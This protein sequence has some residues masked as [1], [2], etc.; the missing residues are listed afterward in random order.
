MADE[1]AIRI[2][3]ITDT[4]AIEA[5]VQE[6]YMPYVAR[7][8]HKPGPMLDDYHDHVSHGRAHVTE[9]ALG[10]AGL[11]VL[12]PGPDALL[13]DNIAVAPRAQG[14]GLG[15]ALIAYAER[16]AREQGHN[17]ITLYTN[18]AMI[19]NIALYQR[20][21]YT[22]THRATEKGFARVYMRKIL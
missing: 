22:E 13:L 17:I 6:A 9:D 12:V 18:A 21:G 2:A 7:I 20:L 8:G 19:E 14:R 3:T 11:L 4:P 10:I 15:R 1:P 5:L 16:T